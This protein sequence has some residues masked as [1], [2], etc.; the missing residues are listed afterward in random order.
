MNTEVSFYYWAIDLIRDFELK[1]LRSR[2]ILAVK[3]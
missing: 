1:S 2:V 3:S